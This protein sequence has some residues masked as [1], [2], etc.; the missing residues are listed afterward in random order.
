MTT[1]VRRRNG[2]AMQD[3]PLGWTRNPLREFDQLLG[4]MSG[5]IESTVGGAAPAVAW[6]P[7]ADVRESDD[8]FHVEIEL[9]GV[10]SKDVDVEANG[11]ELV[12]TGE[13][14]EKQREGVLRRSTRRT[15][16]FEYRLRLPGEIDAERIKGQLSDGVL[17]ITVPKAEIAKPRHVEISET[18]GSTE[19]SG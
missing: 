4:E 12:V 2:G 13:V 9:P 3:R 7:L 16:S 15:G 11:Q 5:L 1:P 17:T 19:S 14:K 8:A 10:K 6:T 18:S